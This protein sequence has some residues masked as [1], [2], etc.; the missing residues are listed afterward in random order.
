MQGGLQ[1]E[2]GWCSNSKWR[3]GTW[4]CLKGFRPKCVGIISVLSHVKARNSSVSSLM[5]IILNCHIKLFEMI[6]STMWQTYLPSF[7]KIIASFINS[8]MGYFEKLLG[9][10]SVHFSFFNKYF[11]KSIGNISG[12]PLRVSLHWVD[13]NKRQYPEIFFYHY[14]IEKITDEIIFKAVVLATKR[15]LSGS[16]YARFK[17][18]QMQPSRMLICRFSQA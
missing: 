7:D 18:Y 12:H 17:P 11:K 9:F 8:Y 10:G 6:D 2:G 1:R 3:G 14:M 15:F 16:F 5:W 4:A 13:R